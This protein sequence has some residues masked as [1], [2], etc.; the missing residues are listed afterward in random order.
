MEIGLGLDHT[1]RLTFAEEAQLSEEAARLGY[2]SIW[3]PEG[4]GHDGFVTCAQRW[5]A[6]RSILT[7]GLGTGISVSPVALRTPSALAM[8]AATLS[9]LTGGRFILGIGTGG[10]Y[11]AEYQRSYGL[12]KLSALALMRDYL[13]VIRTLVAGETANYEGKVITARGLKLAFKAPSPPTPVYLGALGPKM[14][15]LAGEL[16]DGACLNWCSDEQVAWSRRQIDEGA[17]QAGR[18]PSEVKMAEYIRICV[19][20]DVEV[21]RRALTVATMGYAMGRHGATARERSMGYRGHFERMGFTAAL[22]EL[23]RMR[24]R[25]APMDEQIDAFP[26][27]LLKRVGYYG[28]ADGAAAHF[29]RLAE[30]LDVAIVRVVPARPGLDSI[31]AVMRAC[32]P[33]LVPA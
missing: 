8:S 17:E 20:D 28:P 9:E 12:P 25:G 14:L 30:G 21:A 13:T 19:D 24:D 27:D 32:Q 3:T 6:S 4:N 18:D 2:G 7:E 31:R 29:R 10:A 15:H 16:A 23:D 26:T 22:E 1:L 11:G 33:E 5:S